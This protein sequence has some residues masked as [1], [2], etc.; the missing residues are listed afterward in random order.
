MRPV[1]T[2]AARGEAVHCYLGKLM[3]SV[4]APPVMLVQNNQ[5]PQ[6]IQADNPCT[7]A[8]RLQWCTVC[9][10]CTVS[11]HAACCQCYSTLI[12]EQ[13]TALAAQI[14]R[15]NRQLKVQNITAGL[16]SHFQNTKPRCD[17]PRRGPLSTA[18]AGLPCNGALR[19]IPT[20][21]KGKA[22]EGRM[23]VQ[24]RELSHDK[25]STMMPPGQPR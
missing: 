6:C 19:T 2:L 16:S 20:M 1:A 11:R 18:Q 8:A 10:G 7:Q 12:F 23:L 15:K 24:W 25:T 21:G 5:L 17:L 3:I 22:L 4:E 14:Q 9:L 13:I